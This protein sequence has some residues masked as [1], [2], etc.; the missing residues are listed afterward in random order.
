MPQ[1]GFTP[2]EEVKSRGPRK[3]EDFLGTV[4]MQEK[5]VSKMLMINMNDLAKE[6]KIQ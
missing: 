5:G 1:G 6:L 3:I 2:P 4:T